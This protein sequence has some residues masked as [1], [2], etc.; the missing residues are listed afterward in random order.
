MK[1]TLGT[2]FI[3]SMILFYIYYGIRLTENF[4]NKTEIII[5]LFAYVLFGITLL[6][7]G[8]ITKY[9]EILSKKRGPPGPRGLSGV[10]GE[11]GIVGTCEIEHNTMFALLKIKKSVLQ[12]IKNNLSEESKKVFEDKFVYNSE[13][14]TLTNK[15]LDGI[16]NRIVLSKEFDTILLRPDTA[17][18]IKYGKSLK[19]IT[20]YLSSIINEWVINIMNIDE[21]GNPSFF[22][23]VDG[24]FTDTEDLEKYFHNEIE[25]YDIWYWGGTRV[26]KPLEIAVM[27]QTEFRDENGKVHQNTA[28]PMDDKARIEIMEITYS[29]NDTRNLEWLWDATGLGDNKKGEQL[30][31]PTEEYGAWRNNRVGLYGRYIRPAIY[32]PKVR[33][34]GNKRFYPVGCVMLET[35]PENK[36]AIVKKTILVSGDVIIPDKYKVMWKDRRRIH[37]IKNDGQP[38]DGIHSAL[39]W[40]LETSNPDYI[41]IGDIAQ[42][43]TDGTKYQRKDFLDDTKTS[44]ELLK[45]KFNQA[46]P[47][48]YTGIVAV[49]KDLVSVVASRSSPE[50]SYKL[51]GDVDKFNHGRYQIDIMTSN[52]ESGF[53]VLRFKNARYNMNLNDKGGEIMIIDPEKNR[54]LNNPLKE[55]EIENSDLGFGYYGYPYL[56]AD[57][58]SI[59]KFLDLVPE[60]LIINYNNN[61]K[62]YIRHYGGVEPNRYNIFKYDTKTDRFDK[63][64]RVNGPTDVSFSRMKP[65]DPRFG[66]IVEVDEKDKKFLRLRSYAYPDDGFLVYISNITNTDYDE[67]KELRPAG[68]S[69]DHTKSIFSLQKDKGGLNDNN[70]ALFMFLQAHGRGFEE[71]PRLNLEKNRYPGTKKTYTPFQEYEEK[72][73]NKLRKELAKEI[74][75]RERK[76]QNN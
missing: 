73:E 74:K 27:R 56:I 45:A 36:S 76:L 51:N 29:D 16:I 18:N 50:W 12:T 48:R 61:R 44:L 19:D 42:S 11:A 4:N 28:F 52:N 60:G 17:D 54:Q 33:V 34:I 24:S 2:L 46:N 9:W 30:Y 15:L 49:P 71:V 20:G 7:F 39:F 55:T 35:D 31:E 37:I 69:I 64:I 21:K 58:Y 1:N 3:I 40:K 72:E 32:I 23:D 43:K 13:N 6:N 59:F 62:L 38:S 63:A 8:I 22:I 47:G 25:K 66:F 14:N 65:N 68:I 5:Y 26:F 53:N 57:K 10:E 67:N 75:K 41:T 70:K